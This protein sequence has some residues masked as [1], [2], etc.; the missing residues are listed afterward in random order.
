LE[1]ACTYVIWCRNV[2]EELQFP[3]HGP[4]IVLQDNTSTM[5]VA[6]DGPTF[7]HNRHIIGKFGFVKEQIA[8]GMIKLQYVPTKLMVA[9]MLTKVLNESLL[10]HHMT[11][12]S[13]K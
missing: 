7:R 3:Q 8:N 4:T 9:D 13:I 5:D 6:T 2:L 11:S 1:E 10:K 12:C